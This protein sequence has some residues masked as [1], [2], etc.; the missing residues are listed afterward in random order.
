MKKPVSSM[1]NQVRPNAIT[2][3]GT[4]MSVAGMSNRC[5]RLKPGSSTVQAYVA[6]MCG[7]P[8][9]SVT[10]MFTCVRWLPSSYER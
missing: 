5:R 2:V 4:A 9:N 6:N 1:S 8:I 7:P 10:S 3:A